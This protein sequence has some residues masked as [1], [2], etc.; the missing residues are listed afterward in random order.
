LHAVIVE[1][2]A[3]RKE[4]VARRRHRGSSVVEGGR[5]RSVSVGDNVARNSVLR[6]QCFSVFGIGYFTQT[7]TPLF[8][9]I[10]IISGL[11]MH[12]VTELINFESSQR[13]FFI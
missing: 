5:R 1:E 13:Y 7:V 6:A 3:L 11:V 9:L 4:E 2:A 12:N 10:I 8:F